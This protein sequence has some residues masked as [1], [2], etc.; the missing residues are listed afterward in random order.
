MPRSHPMSSYTPWPRILASLV[1]PLDVLIRLGILH[2]VANLAR[3][4]CRLT[5]PLDDLFLRVPVTH[6]ALV[7]A[8]CRNLF[9]QEAADVHPTVGILRTADVD[10]SHLM[11][12]QSLGEQFWESQARPRHRDDR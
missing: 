10:L 9:V 6:L 8:K 4:V 5:R 12:L 11:R 2:G 3:G 7:G 1:A